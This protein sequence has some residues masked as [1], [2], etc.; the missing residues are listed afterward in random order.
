MTEAAVVD[1][2]PAPVDATLQ[3]ARDLI[4]KLWADPDV[5]SKVRA[6][7]KEIFP[8]IKIPEDDIGP[9]IAPLR[10]ENK[11]LSEKL[12]AIIAER[13][14]EKKARE[15]ADQT[16]AMERALAKAREKYA[17]TDEGFNKMVERMKETK[18]FTDAEA[19][20]AWVTDHEPV[21]KPIS[22]PS[23]QPQSLD[24]YGSKKV[25]DDYALLHKDPEAYFDQTVMEILK[26]AAA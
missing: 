21:K 19:A 15:E 5:G 24:L 4:N 18:N 23:W 26:E 22:G 3:R 14:A 13:A 17:L 7:A 6:K 2:K 8:D 16:S 9:A 1:P 12:E 25:N 20:A 11:K 10:E